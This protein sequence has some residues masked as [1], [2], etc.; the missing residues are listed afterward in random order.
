MMATGHMVGAMAFTLG[1][2][3]VQ[4]KVAQWTGVVAPVETGAV[5]AAAGL[6]VPFS[7]GKLSPD[8]DQTPW[9]RRRFGHRMSLHWWGWPMIPIVAL[10]AVGAPFAFFGPFLGWLSH[11]WP[12]D[13]LFGKGGRHVPRGIP[14]WPW[15]SSPR[16]GVGLRVTA[17]RSRVE[18]WA[19]GSRRRHSV[20]EWAFTVVLL[21]VV[22]CELHA[23]G[24]TMPGLL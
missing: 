11:I 12:F 8:V 15:R 7:A 23:L 17:R 4:I 22:G 20:L 9:I 18:R 5:M 13:W 6:S 3:L 10:V 1:L 2:G 19:I 16:H 14:R 21:V 24:G